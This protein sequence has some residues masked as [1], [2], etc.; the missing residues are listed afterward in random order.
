MTYQVHEFQES[1]NHLAGTTGK[2]A[3]GAAQAWAHSTK[4][5]LGAL[6]DKNGSYGLGLNLVCNRLA[7]TVNLEAQA[8]LSHLAFGS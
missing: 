3:Q 6:N 5:L 2:D 7:G 8:A 4:D 1:L